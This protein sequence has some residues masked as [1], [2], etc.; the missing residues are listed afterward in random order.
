M[1]PCI[2]NDSIV[3]FDPLGFRVDLEAMKGY[4]TFPK[5]LG[6]EPYHQIQCHIEDICCGGSG[7]GKSYPS[8]EMQS[9]YFTAPT[10]WDNSVMSLKMPHLS[11]GGLYFA[12]QK[13]RNVI[14]LKGS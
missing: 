11:Q 14:C 1:V 4:P 13:A 9:A 10:D 2:V 7:G 3:L 12:Y 6:F 5:V 8:A